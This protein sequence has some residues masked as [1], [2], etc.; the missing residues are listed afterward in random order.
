[1]HA[2]WTALAMAIALLLPLEGAL[3]QQKWSMMITRPNLNSFDDAQCQAAFDRIKTRTNGALDIKVSFIGSLPIKETEWVRAVRNG[4]LE[5]AVITGD[6]HAGDFPL[7]GL[8]QTPFLFKD[9]VEKNIAIAASFPVMQREANKLNIVLLAARPYAEIGFWSTEPIADITKLQGRKIRAQ[10]KLFSDMIEAA[11][12]VPVP[13][14]F[15]EAYTALQN[16]LVKGIFTGF[17]SITGAKLH[18]VAPYAHG[19]RLANQFPYIGVNK[20]KWDALP[21]G[22]REIVLEE[23]NRT[24]QIIQ[25]NVPSLMNAEIEKQKAGGLKAY[26]PDPPA[27]WFELM[28]DKVGK[29]TL[30]TELKRSGQAGEDLLVAMETAIGRKLR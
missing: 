23:L 17:D 15:A 21:A 5:M 3:A 10:A 12:G 19:I 8:I 16:G 30:A 20:Q 26:N 24:M 9:Q 2:I 6:Y 7:T 28:S 1:M 29:A 27:G 13:V 25:A 14:A 4:D 18:E 11:G 22:T